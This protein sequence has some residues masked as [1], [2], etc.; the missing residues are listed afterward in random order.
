[1]VQGYP[2]AHAGGTGAW[3]PGVD[4]ANLSICCTCNRPT[5][6]L[7]VI[8]G[9]CIAVALVVFGIK[10]NQEW[11]IYC[12]M[13]NSSSGRFGWSFWTTIGAVGGALLTSIIYCYMDR[14]SS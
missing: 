5:Y 7:L 1:M 9:L 12:Q 14:Q 4:R 6:W 11:K 2:R 8:A 13:D 10:A 3:D